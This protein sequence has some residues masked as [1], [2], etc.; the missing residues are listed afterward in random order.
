M[1]NVYDL[2]KI[3][4]TNAQQESVLKVDRNNGVKLH[5][6]TC[7]R[8]GLSL[9]MLKEKHGDFRLSVFYGEGFSLKHLE[10]VKI[11]RKS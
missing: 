1:V 3:T 4:N 6:Y 8:F 2:W 9:M 11:N 10:T 7:K 5:A